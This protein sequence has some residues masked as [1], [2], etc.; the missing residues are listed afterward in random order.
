MVQRQVKITPSDWEI[1]ILEKI[2]AVTGVAVSAIVLQVVRENLKRLIKECEQGEEFRV[3]PVRKTITIDSI[4]IRIANNETVTD[5]EIIE[6][7]GSIDADCN[8]EDVIAV[9]LKLR[10]SKRRNGNGCPTSV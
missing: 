2:S 6:A 10:D 8:K 3:K 4:V 5:E 7:S 9:L 1:E